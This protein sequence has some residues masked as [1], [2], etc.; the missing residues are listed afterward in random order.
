MAKSVI[1]NQKLRE[2][3]TQYRSITRFYGK[4]I[5]HLSKMKL[6][7]RERDETELADE[8]LVLKHIHK[9]LDD[10]RKETQKLIDFETSLA[11]AIWENRNALLEFRPKSFTG[12][13]SVSTPELECNP[14]L[15]DKGTDD[16]ASMLKA[17][18]LS[19][20]MNSQFVKLDYKVIAA[21]LSRRVQEGGKIPGI[22]SENVRSTLTSRI[23]SGINLER[24]R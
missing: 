4:F 1:K 9:R 14:S 19:A 6:N 24:I 5:L 10:M 18:G 23:K 12:E 15:P 13:I 21:E 20:E 16:Y 7:L 11:S 17:L 3:L 22:T 8:I 2:T